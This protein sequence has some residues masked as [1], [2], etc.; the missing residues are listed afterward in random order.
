MNLDRNC[1]QQNGHKQA[2]LCFHLGFMFTKQLRRDS[3]KSCFLAKYLLSENLRKYL[4]LQMRKKILG[5]N[6]LTEKLIL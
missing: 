3:I 1:H 6:Y 5:F 2:L 4:A